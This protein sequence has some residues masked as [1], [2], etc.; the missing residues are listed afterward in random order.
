MADICA[1]LPY[2]TDSG[3]AEPEAKWELAFPPN[4]LKVPAAACL[5]ARRC[6]TPAM[7]ARPPTSRV[8]PRP[9]LDRL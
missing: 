7:D 1:N 4:V 3:I 2:E 6:F 8:R 5:A 9:M